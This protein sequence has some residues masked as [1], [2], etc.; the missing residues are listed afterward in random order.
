VT[1][2]QQPASAETALSVEVPHPPA[3]ATVVFGDRL[4]LAV[5]Y[6][7]R[8][9]TDGVQRGL[10]GPREVPRLWDRHLL[11]CAVLTDLLPDSARIVDVGSGAGLPGIV[12]AL[13]RPDLEVVLVEPMQRRV[14]FLDEV[15]AALGL[16]VKVRVVRGRAEDREVR[17]NVP[18]ADWVTA[19]AVAPLDRLVKWCLPLVGPGGRL[20]ALKGARAADEVAEHGEALRR[21]GAT[22]VEIRTLGKDL[23]AEPTRVVVVAKSRRDG[24]RAVREEN[25]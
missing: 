1:E 23:L 22:V 24:R 7:R 21:A 10:I 17:R 16:A 5:E 19:R 14:D 20:L 15:V 8:L 2:A 13:R 9:S 11:N 18:A 4:P 3:S 25:R 6:V 12:L